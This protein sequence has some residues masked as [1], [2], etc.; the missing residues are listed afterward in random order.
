M[1]KASAAPASEAAAPS[2][3]FDERFLRKLETLSIVV[4]RTFAGLT[5]A[6]RR[7][8]RVGAG[9]EFADH[10]AYAA[11]DDLRYLDWNLYGRVGRLLVRL[12]E[13]DEDLAISVLCDTSASMG[14]GQPRKLDLALQVGA[15]LAYVGL[16]NLDRVALYPIGEVLGTGLPPARG[17]AHILP[18]LR[19]LEGVVPGGRTDLAAAVRAFLRHQRRNRRGLVIVVSDFYDPAGYRQALDL[20]R[21]DRFEIIVVQIS[22]P[23]EIEPGLRGDVTIRDV[24]TGDERELTIAPAVIEAYQKRRTALLRDLEG[25]CRERALPCFCITSDMAFDDVVLR[26]FRAGNVLG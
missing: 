13:E 15:A 22:A 12:F 24:E 14:M 1:T 20:L 5:R 21:H 6:D 3:R 25:F 8:R 17:K 18:M 11:G 2:E 9:I 16:A 19:F 4:K 10:R 23:D 7:T 26:I